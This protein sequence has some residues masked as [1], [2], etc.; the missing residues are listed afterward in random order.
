MKFAHVSAKHLKEIL[1]IWD[2]HPKIF[3]RKE[4]VLEIFKPIDAVLLI[5]MI[6]LLG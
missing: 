1:Y 4:S 3:I 6:F 2:K 5:V